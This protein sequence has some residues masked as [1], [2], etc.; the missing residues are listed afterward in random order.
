[1]FF[2]LDESTQ[3]RALDIAHQLAVG[4]AKREGLSLC[5]ELLVG[6]IDSKNFRS[7]A[8][9]W[10]ELREKP[11][12]AFDDI[13]TPSYSDKLPG[14]IETINDSGYGG[15]V[16]RVITTCF[17]LDPALGRS[18]ISRI[19]RPQSR[20][21][22]AAEMTVAAATELA[23]IGMDILK[24]GYL[25]GITLMG[26]AHRVAPVVRFPVADIAAEIH[27][28]PFR[29][30]ARLYPDDAQK[31]TEAAYDLHFSRR[32]ESAARVGVLVPSMLGGLA[33]EKLFDGLEA[34]AK[35]EHAPAFKA[36]RSILAKGYVAEAA[37]LLIDSGAVSADEMWASIDKEFVGPSP[38]LTTPSSF[39]FYR[40]SVRSIANSLIA[41]SRPLDVLSAPSPIDAKSDFDE[42]S[43][44]SGA[45]SLSPPTSATTGPAAPTTSSSEPDTRPTG[46]PPGGP[47]GVPPSEFYFA[48]EGEGVRGDQVLWD[49]LIDLVFNYAPPPPEVLAKLKGDKLEETVKTDA[50]LGLDVVPKGLALTDGNAQRTVQFKD[51]KMVGDPPRFSLQAPPRNETTNP[52]DW[53]VYVFFSRNRAQLYS[54]FIPIRLVDQFAEGVGGNLVVD[55]DLAQV[56]RSRPE[57]RDATVSVSKDGG[58]WRIHWDIDGY[59]SRSRL[60]KVDT[61]ALKDF[62]DELK[63]PKEIATALVWT[64]LNEKLEVA[65]NAASADAV[66]ECMQKTMT[67][68]W[69]LYDY[70]RN[71]PIVNEALQLIEK[72][73]P[74]SKIAFLM[75]EMAFPWELIYPA[76]HDGERGDYK[77]DLFWGRRFQI[78]SLLFPDSEADKLPEE[79]QQAGA[80]FV[81]MGMNEGI[82]QEE[83]AYPFL[84]VKFQKE[85]CTATL[86]D[87]GKYL[88]NYQEIRA[89]F[90]DPYPASLIYFF[91]HGSEK[92]LKFGDDAN[93]TLG[94]NSVKVDGAR[95]PGWPIIFLNACSAGD[96]SPLSFVSFR[97]K[98]RKKGAAG[99]VAPSFAIPTLFAAAFAKNVL[100]QYAVR[101]PIGQIMLDL[102]RELLKKDNP[103]GLWYSLQCPLDVRAPKN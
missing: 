28:I 40:R 61:A 53:G 21:S 72:L 5:R 96:V 19:G 88:Q 67:T 25:E 64:T 6:L 27:V 71:D 58:N 90:E 23:D 52:A 37:N 48:L 78:E 20:S 7:V 30:P 3:I 92:E 65:A 84:P 59:Q 14:I 86:R 101:L 69:Q 62:L 83:N 50:E 32:K 80:L 38:E 77:P 39:N 97:T 41:F 85:Y 89:V 94:P 4:G 70:L 63:Q 45:G 24:S 49:A 100:D 10:F 74:G 35:A 46:G 1:M 66:R 34:K 44:S 68:G 82:D 12:S 73:P 95:Y 91:C 87:R 81:S 47:A 102:R 33:A 75:E 51:G 15:E 29:Q 22:V 36:S 103:L 9:D 31:L 26:A 18:L 98:F 93:A 43:T 56:G 11:S 57:P 13:I 16:V 2:P 8:E 79:R 17:G 54:H 60:T 42:P 76:W 99:L 55:L